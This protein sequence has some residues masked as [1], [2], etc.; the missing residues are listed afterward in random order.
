MAVPDTCWTTSF[1]TDEIVC[2][3]RLRRRDLLDLLAAL[4]E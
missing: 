2:V 1:A 4:V 3:P